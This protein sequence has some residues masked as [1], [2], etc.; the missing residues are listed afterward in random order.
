M[1]MTHSLVALNA[2]K[3]WLAL[4]T[5]HPTGGGSKSSIMC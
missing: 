5:T 3:L 1:A 4:L 2:A